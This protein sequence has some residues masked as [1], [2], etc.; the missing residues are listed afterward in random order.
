[1]GK[2]R[3]R[4]A[5]ARARTLPK[6]IVED[7]RREVPG[8]SYR[9]L[10]LTLRIRALAFMMDRELARVAA[11]EGVQVDEALILSALRRT[12]APY[13]LRPTD[14]YKLFDITSGAATARIARLVRKSLVERIG[15]M[16]DRR[17]SLVQLS[18]KGIKSI[19]RIMASMAELSDQALDRCVAG[20][21]NLSRLKEDLAQLE[22]GWEQVVPI[23]E[24]PLV[25][26]KEPTPAG[27]VALIRFRG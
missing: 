11:A 20:T 21:I 5:L 26:L 27:E 8:L 9:G 1:M 17:S 4:E 22:S 19:D 2:A 7:W 14:I 10:Q 13:R 6:T 24:N 18:P 12:G 15:H 3:K 25:R 16:H 23:S